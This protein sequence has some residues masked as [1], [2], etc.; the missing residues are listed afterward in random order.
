MAAKAVKNRQR[1]GVGL[2]RSWL[3]SL[4]TNISF[5]Y[6]LYQFSTLKPPG[7]GKRPQRSPTHHINALNSSHDFI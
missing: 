7:S 6:D 4:D 5:F 3:F 2:R 1:E